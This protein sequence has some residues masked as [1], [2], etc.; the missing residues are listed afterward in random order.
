MNHMNLINPY[1]Y[2]G[3]RGKDLPKGFT[4]LIRLS[5]GKVTHDDIVAAVTNVMNITF[6]DMRAPRRKQELVD[7]R[8]IYCYNVK[9]RLGWTLVDIGKRLSSRDHTT[10][11]HNIATYYDLYKTNDIFKEKADWVTEELEWK[12]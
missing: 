1:I 9:V 5:S 7:A 3:I 8:R 2:P 12:P 10:I 6:D 11:I 4:R